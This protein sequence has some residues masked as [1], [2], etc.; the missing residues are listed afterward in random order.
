MGWN[1]QL[2]FFF[3]KPNHPRQALPFFELPAHMF[4]KTTQASGKFHHY[5]FDFVFSLQDVWHNWTRSCQTGKIFQPSWCPMSFLFGCRIGPEIDT[6][7]WGGTAPAARKLREARRRQGIG[8]AISTAWPY[9][10]RLS[11]YATRNDQSSEAVIWRSRSNAHK[12]KDGTHGPGGLGLM[13]TKWRT[14]PTDLGIHCGRAV[15]N[16][17]CVSL[18]FG[19]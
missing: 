9:R 18:V 16:M 5:R 15:C 4:S 6:V 3:G 7:T 14:V 2:G 11:P 10:H 8:F 17:F 12:V 13:H 19:T 1:H